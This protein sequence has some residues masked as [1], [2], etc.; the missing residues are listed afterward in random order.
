MKKTNKIILLIVGILLVLGIFRLNDNNVVQSVKSE[1][2]LLAFTSNRRYAKMNTFER[3]LTLPFSLFFYDNY[4]Y[5]RKGIYIEDY[6]I[7]EN[8]G[9]ASSSEIKV[10]DY[11][12]TNVQV[13]GVDE[14]DII[15]TDGYYIYSISENNVIITNTQ[16]PKN[17][18]IE[19]K[20]YTD[21]A[22]PNDLLLY[23]NYL[24]VFS[25]VY[26]NE[27]RYWYYNNNNTLVE[28]FN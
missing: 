3:I 21:S 10:R 23:K 7:N 18:F 4:Y 11:S 20:I 24:V 6:A 15:K 22:I 13:E 8:S 17:P 5:G 28:V 16:D 25:Y 14:A 26:E 9:T 1:K 19:S 27:N 2:Q 12:K